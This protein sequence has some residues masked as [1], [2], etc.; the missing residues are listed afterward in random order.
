MGY[1]FTSVTYISDNVKDFDSVTTYDFDVIQ[2]ILDNST[3]RHIW[4]ILVDFVP[5]TLKHFLPNPGS[6]VPIICDAN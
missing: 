6:G 3:N 4:A 1:N 5:D 2:Y